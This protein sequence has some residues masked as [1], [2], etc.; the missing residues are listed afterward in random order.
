[1]PSVYDWATKCAEKIREWVN[2]EWSL[3]EF[4]DITVDQG[5]AIK[6]HADRIAAIVALHA[7]PLVTLL[8]ECGRGVH[9]KGYNEESSDYPPCPKSH[10]FGDADDKCTCGAD[11]WNARVDAALRG[12]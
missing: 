11:A 9:S 10:E 3:R 1:M 2:H 12:D 4:S 5:E 8:R 6:M 7:G